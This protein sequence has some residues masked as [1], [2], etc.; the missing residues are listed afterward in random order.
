[1]N[2]KHQQK[3]AIAVTLL[4]SGSLF[5]QDNARTFI[6]TFLKDW[7]VPIFILFI[8]LTTIIG[9]IKNF[10]LITDRNDTGSTLKGFQ[11]VGMYLLYVI[12][13]FAILA[14]IMTLANEASDTIQID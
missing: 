7:L 8:A 14:G 3:I 9:V 2:T 10:D 1:M 4:Q 12:I 13:A 11:N 6:N 5:A